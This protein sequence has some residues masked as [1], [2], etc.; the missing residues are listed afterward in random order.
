MLMGTVAQPRRSN[1]HPVLK[2]DELAHSRMTSWLIVALIV[3]AR[4]ISFLRASHVPSY[5]TARKSLTM[6][7]VKTKE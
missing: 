7:I 3:G 2:N 4:A 1:D 5:I 6:R